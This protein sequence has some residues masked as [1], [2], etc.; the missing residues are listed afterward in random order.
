MILNL[1]FP[2]IFSGLRLAEV[3][4]AFQTTPQND[5]QRNLIRNLFRVSSKIENQWNFIAENSLKNWKVLIV[6]AVDGDLN[7]SRA[8]DN[9]IPSDKWCHTV[10]VCNDTVDMNVELE[11]L[12]WLF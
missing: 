12:N 10:P 9:L 6:D 2:S 7:K 11:Q 1:Y 3:Y 5:V 4:F 8:E